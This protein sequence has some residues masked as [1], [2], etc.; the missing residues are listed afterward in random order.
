MGAESVEKLEGY[1]VAGLRRLKASSYIYIY[2]SNTKK[3]NKLFVNRIEIYYEK[4][5]HKV[6]RN[7]WQIQTLFSLLK[8][9]N[10]KTIIPKI[11]YNTNLQTLINTHDFIAYLIFNKT[12]KL[13]TYLQQLF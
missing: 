5:K 9:V 6:R 7:I 12:E 3:V 13:S 4:I 11:Y 1:G 8:L 2:R 10:L